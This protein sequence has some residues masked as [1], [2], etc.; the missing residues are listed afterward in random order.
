M[1]KPMCVA[2]SIQH[3]SI[4]RRATAPTRSDCLTCAL[5]RTYVQ[6]R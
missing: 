3:V 1:V 4:L 2:E 5:M 6:L